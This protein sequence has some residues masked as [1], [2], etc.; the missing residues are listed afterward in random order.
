MMRILALFIFVLLALSACRDGSLQKETWV[1]TLE[2]TSFTHLQSVG[3]R[4]ESTAQDCQ[5]NLDNNEL[6]KAR[7]NLDRVKEDI[8]VL[9]YYDIPITE[10]RQLI[11]DAGRFHALDRHQETVAHLNRA[12]ELLDEMGRH[13][14]EALRQA[15]QEP[16][17]MI[18]KLRGTL[19]EERNAVSTKYLVEISKSVAQQL[20]TLGHRVNMMAIKSDLILSGTG[21]QVE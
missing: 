16:K 10:V 2:Q 17:T 15:L 1:P 21:L 4:L 18:D 6:S 5:Q 20:A 8:Q 13:G 19:E 14:N 11:Y 12:D 3:R 7:K 9:L